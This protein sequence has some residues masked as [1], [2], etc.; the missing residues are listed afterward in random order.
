MHTEQRTSIR[1]SSAYQRLP[2]Q[3]ATLA[4]LAALDAMAH[5]KPKLDL[6]PRLVKPLKL[7]VL[8]APDAVRELDPATVAQWLREAL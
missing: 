1:P 2:L 8:T 7:V 6:R 3:G 4:D 5:A